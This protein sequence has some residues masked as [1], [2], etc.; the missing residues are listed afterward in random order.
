MAHLPP[1]Q[2]IFGQA[3]SFGLCWREIVHVL[4]W[5]SYWWIS[6]SCADVSVSCGQ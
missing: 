5:S 2:S 3:L 6:F 4:Q 1:L